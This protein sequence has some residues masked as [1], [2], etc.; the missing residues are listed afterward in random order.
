MR[1]KKP[2]A[3]KLQLAGVGNL[4]LAMACHEG[5]GTLIGV[6]LRNIAQDLIDYAPGCGA[7]TYVE[8]TN[9]GQMPCGARLTRFGNTEQYFCANCKPS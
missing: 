4:S 2:T 9:G 6:R 3:A 5:G 7:P 1:T 8:G